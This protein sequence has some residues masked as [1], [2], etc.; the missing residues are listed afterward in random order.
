MADLPQPTKIYATQSITSIIGTETSV[1]AF[2]VDNVI[3]V[4][5]LQ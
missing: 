3:I 1:K 5:N 4:R 2:A